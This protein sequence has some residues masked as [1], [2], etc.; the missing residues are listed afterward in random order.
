MAEGDET[1]A[2]HDDA[3]KFPAKTEKLF[4]YLQVVSAA[5]DSLAHGANDVA[6]SVGP[7]AAIV[8]IHQTAKVDSKVEVPIWILVMG[9]AGISIGLLTYGYNV[10]KSIGIK[11]A[12]I[13]PSR[14]FS[15][16]MGSSI[17][18][19]IG[20]NLGI[21]LS[22]THCQVGATVGVGMCEIR[23]AATA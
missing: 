15:I 16:E 13:T 1:R 3:E 22:T 10:I 5:F 14:G 20:S 23:G 6:N 9:G 17:V 19:I 21:P 4:S 18:V 2:M 8:G 12:K 7:L 11:L